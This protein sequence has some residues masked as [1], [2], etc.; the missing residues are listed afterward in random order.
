M[1]WSPGT[2]MLPEGLCNRNTHIANP[3][4]TLL[5]SL[6]AASTLAQLKEHSLWKTLRPMVCTGVGDVKIKRIRFV[7]CSCPFL[8]ALSREAP[9]RMKP[10]RP[11]GSWFF[12]CGM[13]IHL[14]IC[15]RVGS[16]CCLSPNLQEFCRLVRGWILSNSYVPPQNRQ[17]VFPDS[18]SCL[19]ERL[20]R[21][22]KAMETR[23]T[24]CDFI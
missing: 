9:Q 22:H 24:D 5:F 20:S 10:R 4:S 12:L 14:E 18:D 2:W 3:S 15:N 6:W 23:A 8:P 7:S 1:M 17:R 11:V 21:F 19:T 13:W 16:G